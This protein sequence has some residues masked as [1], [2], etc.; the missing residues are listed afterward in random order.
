MSSLYERL[1]AAPA[2]EA[3]VENFYRQVLTDERISSFFDDVDMERQSAKQKAFL[4]MVTGGPNAYSGLDMRHAHQ[5]LVN[6][7]LN[8]EHFD[9]VVEILGT[10]LRDLGAND[11][12]IAEVAAIA[13][14]VRDDVLCR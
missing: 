14:S 2:I 7:G 12:D 10:T 8:D 11:A 9:A 1:G 4:T 5:P 6:R 13:N 3:A